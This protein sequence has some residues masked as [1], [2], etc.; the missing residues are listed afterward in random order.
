MPKGPVYWSLLRLEIEQS[1][2]LQALG[3]KLIPGPVLFFLK[4]G[5]ILTAVVQNL[6]KFVII[7]WV[8]ALSRLVN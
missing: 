8:L 4:L 7:I 3:P 6:T 5:R 2:I 1:T